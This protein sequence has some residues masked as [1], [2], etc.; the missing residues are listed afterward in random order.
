MVKYKNWLFAIFV[1]SFGAVKCFDINIGLLYESNNAQIE[2]VF[3]KA[4]ELAN[5]ALMEEAHPLVGRTAE[6]SFGNSYDSSRKLCKML[7]GG[8]AAIFGP[9]TTASSTHAMSICDA[10]EVP[11]IDTRW[12][13]ETKLPT[14]NI[15]PHPANIILAIRDLVNSYEWKGFTILYESGP[16]LPALDELL[17]MYGKNSHTITVR[18]YD[19]HLQGNYRNILRKIKRG[20]DRKIVIIGSIETL[21]DLLQ[22]IQQV[23]LMNERFQYIIANLD[24]H[25]IDL[26]PYQY[27]ESNITGIRLFDPNDFRVKLLSEHLSQAEEE[28]EETPPEEPEVGVEVEEALGEGAEEEKPNEE[29]NHGGKTDITIQMALIYDGVHLLAETLRHVGSLEL[30]EPIN[31]NCHDSST[32]ETGFTLVNFMK[33][34]TFQGITGEIKFDHQGLRT[35][36]VMDIIELTAAGIVKTG[37]WSSDVGLHIER[38]PQKF[39]LENGGRKFANKTFRVIT[40]I[41]PPYG[42][43]KETS[44]KLTGND[45]YEGFGIELIHELS[46]M[47]GFNYTFLIQEDKVYGSY[48]KETKQWSGMI[49]EIIEGR[50]DLAI[51]DLTMTSDREMGVDFTMPFMNL[52]ISILYRKP[53][54][55]PPELFSFMSPF[56]KE[57]WLYLGGAYLSVS[58]SLFILGRLSPAEWD[59]PY[60]CIEE[61]TVLEN[62]FSF[63]NALWFTIGALLQQGSE[64]APKAPSTRTV[65]S[66]WWFFTLIMVSSYTANLAAFLTVESLSSPINS[67]E[68]LANGAGGVKYGAKKDGST[69][70]FFKDAK[71]ETYQRMHEY[72]ENHPELLPSSNDEGVA[73]AENENYAF[74]MESTSIEYTIERK[75]NLTQVGGLLDEKGYGIAMIKNSPY[76]NELSQAILN[77]QEQGKLSKMKTK[78]WKEKRGGGACSQKAQSDSAAELGM[79][80][81]GGVYFV[82]I[83]GSVL[84]SVY[85][86]IEWIYIIFR[87]SRAYSVPFKEELMDELK[88]VLKCSGNTKEVKHRKSSSTGSRNSSMTLESMEL[89]NSEKTNLHKGKETKNDA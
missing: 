24:L 67:A 18:R 36:F 61:P 11:Y 69:Y 7:R 52:G 35:D 66:I 58:L 89:D 47:L 62:Q 6:I 79:A 19:L 32:W 17:Q 57:V 84:A 73:K 13:A 74:L 27:S 5:T 59:N 60:P 21:P 4:I 76:R 40:A 56:S 33:S 51:T 65:A 48:N 49:K 31:L 82:L 85:G 71:Y 64:I 75:C 50:A 9:G 55:E 37:Q 1:I 34:T 63:S 10:K 43:L 41:T 81:L 38:Q 23:G 72:M 80:N 29:N 78:W 3:H 77:L 70:N 12:D 25:T 28:G 20:H 2:K 83:V 46:L 22:Q 88:F 15:H 44:Q 30:F 87:R 14:I 54:K 45:Q 39:V 26:E 8:V 68:D 53:I 86:V 42:M 16:Y